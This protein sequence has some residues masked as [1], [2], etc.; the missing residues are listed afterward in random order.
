MGGDGFAVEVGRDYGGNTF[1]NGI[2]AVGHGIHYQS[3]N[4]CDVS[5]TVFI[6]NQ[7]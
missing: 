3:E 7:M 5:I 2:D 6:N 4:G 1:F